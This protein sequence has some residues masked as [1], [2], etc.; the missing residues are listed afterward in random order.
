MDQ[1]METVYQEKIRRME[2]D[3]AGLRTSRRIMMAMLE[4][5]Q[6]T[7]RA[8]RDRLIEENR[9]LRQKNAFYLRKLWQKRTAAGGDGKTI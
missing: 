8:E 6:I 7:G 3:I 2:E 9:R 1:H 4:Q 5:S